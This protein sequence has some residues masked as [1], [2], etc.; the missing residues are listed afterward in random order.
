M[1]N[2]RVSPMAV[3]K[4]QTP[5]WMRVVII[6]VAISF[7]GG[8]V[9]VGV[10][11]SGKGGGNTGQQA[12][13]TGALDTAQ[14]QSSLD[15]ALAAA[16]AQPDNPEII[17]TLGNAY[18][19]YAAALTNAGRD[20]EAAP[21]WQNAVIQYDKVLAG[22]PG[23]DIVLGDKAFALYYAGSAEARAALQAFVDAASDNAGLAQQ[24]QTARGYL[25]QL[26]SAPATT[27]P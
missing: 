5:L 16:E 12:S 21:Y 13:G 20:R 27:T 15:A 17:E 11:G 1:A 18:F 6:L 25:T 26:S 19:D 9:V 7:V 2:K 10:A 3:N 22:N 4:S 14:L 8:L 24:V 23:N